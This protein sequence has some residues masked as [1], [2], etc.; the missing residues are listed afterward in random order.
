[1]STIIR[2]YITDNKITEYLFGKSKLSQFVSK[3]NKKMR[4]Y[5]GINAYRHM[6]VEDELTR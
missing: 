3:N 6:K 2:T 4:V 5:T 1:M